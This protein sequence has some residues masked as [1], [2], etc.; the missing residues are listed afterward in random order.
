MIVPF[1]PRRAY[2]T[3][4]IGDAVDGGPPTAPAGL[5]PAEAAYARARALAIEADTQAKNDETIAS[6]NRTIRTWQII[7]LI[8]TAAALFDYLNKKKKAR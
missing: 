2:L 5:S 4:G 1:P 7:A 8:I 3:R 6:L